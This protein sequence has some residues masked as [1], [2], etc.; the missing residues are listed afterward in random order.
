MELAETLGII[1]AQLSA[2]KIVS[3]TIKTWGGR[4][5]HISSRQSRELIRAQFLKGLVRYQVP[6]VV[7]DLISAPGM[8]DEANISSQISEEDPDNIGSPFF[9]IIQIEVIRDDGSSSKIAGSVFGNVPHIVQ[10]DEYDDTFAF[11]PEGNHLLTFRNNDEPGAVSSVLSILSDAAVNIA[12]MNVAR[13]RTSNGT[14]ALCFMALDDN[15]PTKSM[16]ALKAL[17]RVDS[18][19][20]IQLT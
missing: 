11:K 5:A 9:N 4:D 18:V 7:P 20:K 13:L 16:K 8:A 1:H 6:D 17:T 2:S 3:T 14:K 15:I 10:I 12:S 19:A